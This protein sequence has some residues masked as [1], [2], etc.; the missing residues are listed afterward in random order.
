MLAQIR[1]HRLEQIAWW[2]V[3]GLFECMDHPLLEVGGDGVLMNAVGLAQITQVQM[4]EQRAQILRLMVMRAHAVAGQVIEQVED[5]ALTTGR[6]TVEEEHVA[7]GAV[8]ATAL[9]N[10]RCKLQRCTAQRIDQAQRR[11]L[12]GMVAGVLVVARANHLPAQPGRALGR[13]GEVQVIEVGQAG[14]G[15][16][17]QCAQMRREAFDLLELVVA[18]GAVALG[19]IAVR[20]HRGERVREAPLAAAGPEAR[21]IDQLRQREQGAML[22][23]QA[24]QGGGPQV[25]P[26]PA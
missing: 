8:Q 23:A 4:L 24:D 11:D 16:P 22:A 2:Q 25:G 19:R 9:G 14:F 26:G 10:E 12:V 15:K 6:E 3:A 20:D 7:P 5:A 17:G 18:Q 1:L 21:G 13:V